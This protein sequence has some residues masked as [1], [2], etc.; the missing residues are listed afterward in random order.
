[1]WSH[2]V[3]P[4]FKLSI[5]EKQVILL[6]F[7]IE[8]VCC[9]IEQKTMWWLQSGDNLWKLFRL[10]GYL[11]S[12][13]LLSM[14]LLSFSHYRARGSLILFMRFWDHHFILFM[15]EFDTFFPI[16]IWLNFFVCWSKFSLSGKHPYHKSCFKELTHPKCEVCFQFVRLIFL[17][18]LK[19]F[20]FMVVTFYC[21]SYTL[22]EL[23]H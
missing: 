7:I 22:E 11:F 12:S 13:R 1:M 5:H 16:C 8:N 2:A 23:W 6:S 19:L 15:V 18:L 14:P 9:G 20:C 4:M 21:I 17:C 3:P 10:H